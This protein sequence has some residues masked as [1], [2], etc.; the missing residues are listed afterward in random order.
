M[1]GSVFGP[2]DRVVKFSAVAAA[3]YFLGHL[4]WLAPS[5]EDID[6]INFALALRDYDVAAHQPH[7]PGYPVF[8]ALGR[9][10]LAVVQV[11]APG[12]SQ[13]RAEA[14][15]LAFWS[16]LGGA[17]AIVAAASL[18]AS[19]INVGRDRPQSDAG[20]VGRDRSQSD[21]DPAAD[22]RRDRP[23]SSSGP[24]TDWPLWGAVLLALAPGFW[25]SGLRPMSDM[26]G[27]AL[28]LAAQALALRGLGHPAALTA[29]A[30]I[31]ALAMG[32][33]VQT[34]LL[35][36]PLLLVAVAMQRRAGVVWM[37][38]RPGAAFVAAGLAWGIPLLALSGG[39]DGYLRALGTQADEDFAWV[40][41]VLFNPSP[42]RVAFALYDTFVPLW[43]SVPLATVVL[44]LAALGLIVV[45]L[46]ARRALLF[47]SIAFVPYAAFHL[48]LQETQHVRY[49]LPVLVAVV[50]LVAA[51]KA[52][53]LTRWV[54]Q[55]TAGRPPISVAIV[56]MVLLLVSCAWV[57][58]SGGIVYG[59][60]AH[61][62]F[63]AIDH[64]QAASDDGARP[65]IYSH[66]ALRRALQAAPPAGAR[67]VDPRRNYE[68]LDLV[69]HW[70]E[71]RPEPAWFLADPRR[72]DLALIDPRSRIGAR[73]RQQH[74]QYRWV[75]A[76]LPEL[77]GARPI[78]V[79]WYRFD[80]PPGWFAAEGW[81]L[82]PETGGLARATTMGVDH[83]PID[84]YVRRRPGP[85]HLV[86]G[87]LHLGGAAGGSAAFTLA[88]D[89]QPIEQWTFD[90]T[91]ALTFLRFIELP[92]GLSSGPGPFAHLQIAARHVDAGK[93]TPS[94]AIRQFDIQ[95]ADSVIYGFGEGWHEEEYESAT[96][97]RWRW[98]SDRSVI[99][100]AP[101]SA[102]TLTLRGESP[103]KYV[104]QA[105]TVRVTAGGRTVAQ[106][107][108]ADDFSWT[109]SVPRET[110]GAAQGAIAI[111]TDRVYLPGPAE[112]T[113]D[114]RRLGLRLF[115]V[116][117][118][119][120]IR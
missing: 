90:P 19:L 32:V 106:L 89:G 88:I 5:L 107:S 10:S 65:A 114:A 92:A 15:A 1:K 52:V 40:D 50:W 23:G 17:I 116:R 85:M 96:G 53:R 112:G 83:A 24:A 20:D 94:V 78:G 11:V 54:R 61:P 39:I 115:D 27:L 91:A 108:P 119:T 64:M 84:A 109:V 29:S 43:G 36:L 58:I 87:G 51:G 79:D 70:L 103:L 7:P 93:P 26:F 105:P 86:V 66:Y 30:A 120:A 6:S 33:R 77:G 47:A 44:V 74:R 62:S 21:G 22:V 117:V 55:P 73:A 76:Q 41:M 45:A 2:C 8:I 37:L 111:E 18:F 48:L 25:V 60:D 42:R 71:Q 34:A 4:P 14:L 95:A 110:V 49:S 46:R 100:V 28:A 72:T 13:A 80:S 56:P 113:T 102:V 81:S 68:W 9:M 99:R 59:R 38:T 3:I 118:D 75:A 82:T 12:L 104:G 31:A 63:L 35:T 57:S 97:L 16:A 98:S 101:P 67:I 69:D